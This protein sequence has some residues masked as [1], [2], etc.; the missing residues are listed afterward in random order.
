MTVKRQKM[1]FTPADVIVT[2]KDSEYYDYEGWQNQIINIITKK[3]EQYKQQ[4]LKN[5]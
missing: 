1:F 2:T 4:N 5:G 3:I